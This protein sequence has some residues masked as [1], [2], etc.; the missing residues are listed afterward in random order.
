VCNVKEN[1]L[2]YTL[3]LGSVF[4]Y[5]VF[6]RDIMFGGADT[7]AP[8]GAGENVLCFLFLFLLIFERQSCVNDFAMQALEYGNDLGK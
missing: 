7:S 3:I 4:N 6:Y 1:L 5:V 2:F 8:P